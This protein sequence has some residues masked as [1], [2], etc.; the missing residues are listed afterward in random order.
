MARLDHPVGCA[1]PRGM[2][3]SF[4]DAHAGLNGLRLGDFEVA[5]GRVTDR[6]AGE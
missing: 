2:T 1:S 6:F 4:A 5:K 3:L